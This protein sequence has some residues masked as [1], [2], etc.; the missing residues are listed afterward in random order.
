LLLVAVL[1]PAAIVV[2]NQL[3]IETLSGERART[4]LFPSL[5]LSTAAISCCAGRYL[6]PFWFQ[7][8]LFAW[9]LVLL[10]LLVM[11]ARLTNRIE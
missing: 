11:S 2:T 5:V 8:I 6:H 1:L 7:A 9:C 3:L 10:D 4:W